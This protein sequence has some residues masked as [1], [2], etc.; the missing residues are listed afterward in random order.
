MAPLFEHWAG[1]SFLVCPCLTIAIEVLAALDICT[2]KCSVHSL[3]NFLLFLQVLASLGFSSCVPHVSGGLSSC[4][5][6]L[7]PIF[8]EKMCVFFRSGFVVFQF[9]SSQLFFGSSTYFSWLVSPSFV[10]TSGVRHTSDFPTMCCVIWDVP[11]KFNFSLTM[12]GFHCP[13]VPCCLITLVE[14]Y[15]YLCACLHFLVT[16]SAA[17]NINNACFSHQSVSW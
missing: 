1:C 11:S 3:L 17:L 12:F 5:N 4:C 7:A 14:G 10:S 13:L 16:H 6:M 2:F 9:Q 15:Y 8:V